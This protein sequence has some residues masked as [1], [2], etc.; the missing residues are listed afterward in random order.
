[1]WDKKGLGLV[2]EKLP[3]KLDFLYFV[4][5]FCGFIAR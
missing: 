5:T 2:E 3:L 1:M 4:L